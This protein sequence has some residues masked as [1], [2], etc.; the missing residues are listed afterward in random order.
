[1]GFFSNFTKNWTVRTVS[2]RALKELGTSLESYRK[3]NPGKSIDLILK[4][5]QF[6]KTLNIRDLH[7][8]IAGNAEN[9]IIPLPDDLKRLIPDSGN[10]TYFL[11]LNI[12]ACIVMHE[13]SYDKTIGE[14]SDAEAIFDVVSKNFDKYIRL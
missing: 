12:V 14:R 11:V 9:V 13:L 6:Y 3:S 4:D 8:H 5:R 7:G 2:V 1:M 10:P